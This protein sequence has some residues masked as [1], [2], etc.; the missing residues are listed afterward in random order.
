MPYLVIG[1][2]FGPFIVV[3]PRRSRSQYCAPGYEYVRRSSRNHRY[4]VL[5]R[6]SYVDPAYFERELRS[7]YGPL[8]SERELDRGG[9]SPVPSLESRSRQNAYNYYYHNAPATA[10]PPAP[11]P[12]RAVPRDDRFEGSNT[13]TPAVEAEIR[14][15]E[16]EYL[17]SI[18]QRDALPRR[19][20]ECGSLSTACL[21]RAWRENESRTEN[22][23]SGRNGRGS[24][25]CDV[26]G[27]VNIIERA[28]RRSV[29]FVNE[30]Q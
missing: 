16:N 9:R 4:A 5:E 30:Y 7:Y 27:D 26:E 1:F 14:E 29:R 11:S 12:L 2:R 20:T 22:G 21:C 24:L 25:R 6:R 10:A 3:E 28:P 23:N 19:C 13:R 8:H 18:A 15:L 17:A